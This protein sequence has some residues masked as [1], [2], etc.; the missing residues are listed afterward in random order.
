MFPLWGVCQTPS[1]TFRDSLERSLQKIRNLDKEQ[2]TQGNM[3]EKV[4]ILCLLSKEYD[5]IDS[6]KT[7]DFAMEALKISENNSYDRGIIAANFTMGRALMYIAP[8]EALHY[9][10]SGSDLAD[11][12]IQDDASSSLA[13]I[14]A[15]GTY[16]LGLTY[17]YLG[18]HNK[19]LE[20]TDK[21]IPVVKKL[22]DRLFLA[23]IYTNLGVKHINLQNLESAY[24]NLKQARHIYRTLNDPKET[25]FSVIQLAM[26]YEN[27]DSLN[28]MH[29]TLKE[30]KTLLKKY[31]NTFDRFSC[32]LQE[33]QYFLRTGQPQKTINLLD[34]V[35]HLV[36][37]DLG[38]VP[39]G[40]IMQRY[41]KAY[42]DLGD[43][44][45]AI[46]FTRKYIE[47]AKK[48]D[49]DLS[50]YQGLY[51]LSEYHANLSNYKDAYTAS[52]EASEIYDRLET[53]KTLEKLEELG[54]KYRTVENEN[55]ILALKV[56]NEEKKSQ[57]YFLGALASVLALI[58][59]IGFY[60]YGRKLRQ[61]RKKERKREAEVSLL[62]HEQ[63]NKIFSAMID[64]QEK[65]RKRLAIDLHDGLGGRLS[66]ISLNLSKLDKDRPAD[67]PKKQ[68]QKAMKDLDDSL[69]ELRAIARN[70]M[71]ETLVKYGLQAA[72]KDYCSSMTRKDTKV[73]LQFY[74]T[75][76]GI[77]L[78]QQVTMY[79]VIQEL[80]NN[81]LKHANASEVL[82]QYM[83]D[84]N[85]VD[86][87]VEDNGIG[88]Q[89][90]TQESGNSGMGLHNLRTRVAY[91]NGELDFHSEENEG[92]TVNVHITIDAA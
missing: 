70:M 71:P 83:R 1:M 34:T 4:K 91:L 53:A 2:G 6:A 78:R 24:T 84:K 17:G 64:G 50:L 86:I 89:K 30:A 16:N 36:E 22:E 25:T 26:V 44:K 42:A 62:K 51:K 47:N 58:L 10:K 61:A 60:A 46:S 85:Q 66:G 73:T 20:L 40:M 75:D 88:M 72:L 38:S 76:K 67:Y 56:I 29:S 27:M 49:S 69:S 9:L 13:E 28:R 52:E 5:G 82:V 33:S 12:A 11:L 57:A 68:L 59:F 14:W 23:N 43:F 41:A 87:T 92:T 8:K 63:Q 90:K 39:Y 21:V 54:M 74:G 65:E 81:A 3:P 15:N 77:D 31:P 37:N 19:E 55:E 45:S 7:F 80:I 48:L 79:R 32:S 18:Q 35:L